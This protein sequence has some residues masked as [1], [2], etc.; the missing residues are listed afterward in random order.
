MARDPI[1]ATDPQP[2]PHGYRT[3]LLVVFAVGLC[4]HAAALWDFVAH[5][6]S[7]QVP[8][9]DGG[10][11]WRMAG[12]IATGQVQSDAPYHAAPL[13]PHLLA[14]VRKLGGGLI[15]TYLLQMVF[16]FATALLIAGISRKLFDPVVSVLAAGLFLALAEPLFAST[17]VLNT[18]WWVL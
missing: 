13:Y 14:I 2:V 1:A 16:R 7:A 5:N 3:A 4:V 18:A 15:A 12:E 11:Y 9:G 6:P 17:R 10:V 8:I